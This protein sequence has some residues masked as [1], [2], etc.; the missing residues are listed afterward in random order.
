[1][2]LVVLNGKPSP[3]LVSGNTGKYEQP[4]MI[5]LFSSSKWKTKPSFSL[6]EYNPPS[7]AF[8]KVLKE[9][10]SPFL[11]SGNRV[12]LTKPMVIALLSCSSGK[13][14]AQC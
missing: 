3:I 10:P 6:G 9:K 5:V 7:M 4:T 13:N 12:K 2:I 1:V 14:Q 8:S 11:D